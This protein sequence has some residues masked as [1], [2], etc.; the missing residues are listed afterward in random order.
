M[1]KR[2]SEKESEGPKAAPEDVEASF[3]DEVETVS[4]D[5]LTADAALLMLRALRKL[6]K[7]VNLTATLAKPTG[8]VVVDG[9]AFAGQRAGT[10]WQFDAASL[11]M[12]CRVAGW[13]KVQRD[14]D[15]WRLS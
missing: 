2:V 8:R 9:H 13:A 4:V 15:V 11:D 6:G 14:G 3:P 5:G 7:P 1:T 12:A 10:A